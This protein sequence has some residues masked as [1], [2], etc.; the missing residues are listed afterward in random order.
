MVGEYQ[1]RTLTGTGR[2]KKTV[3]GSTAKNP[4]KAASSVAA[5]A[6]T[7]VGFFCISSIDVLYKNF[8]D[9]KKVYFLDDEAFLE[10]DFDRDG[11]IYEIYV[12]LTMICRIGGIMRWTLSKSKHPDKGRQ[13]R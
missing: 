4:R 13:T 11:K 2:R 1:R 10:H 9:T 6:I 3:P 7:M 5:A 12:I 8:C